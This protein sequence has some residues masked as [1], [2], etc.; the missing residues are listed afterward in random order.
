MKIVRIGAMWCPACIMMNK[1]W[2]KITNEFNDIEFIDLDLDMDE[3]E[4]KTYNP[5]KTLPVIIA[6]HEKKEIKRIIG[7]KSYEEIID[8]I[9]EVRGCN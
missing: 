4:V 3:E 7:E 5:G 6:Y 8:F 1:F 2:N 9:N